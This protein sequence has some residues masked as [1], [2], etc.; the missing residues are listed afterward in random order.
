MLTFELEVVICEKAQ[1]D[2]E[3]ECQGSFCSVGV[4]QKLGFVRRVVA[5]GCNCDLQTDVVICVFP[6]VQNLKQA[7]LSTH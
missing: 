7:S 4:L 6:I 1:F 2:E 3:R 5:W